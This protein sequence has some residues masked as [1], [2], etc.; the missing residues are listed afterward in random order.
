MATRFS[1]EVTCQKIGQGAEPRG[2]EWQTLRT[3]QR[4]EADRRST[5]R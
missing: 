1:Q 5:R 2:T 3:T 4:E